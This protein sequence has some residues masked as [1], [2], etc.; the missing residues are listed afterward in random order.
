MAFQLFHMNELYSNADGSIQ[1]IELVG[2]ADGQL[3]LGGHTLT[4]TQD[5]TTH[6]YTFDADLPSAATLNRSVLVATQGFADLGVVTPDYIVPSGFLFTG[7]GT[8]TFAEGTGGISSIL[9][10]AALPTGGLLSANQTG[11]TAMNSPTNFAGATGTAGTPGPDDITGTAG[12]DHIFGLAANDNISGEGGDDTLD[13]GDGADLLVGDSLSNAGISFGSGTFDRLPDYN[14]GTLI[15]ALVVPGNRYS[16]AADDNISAATVLPHASVGSPAD[17]GGITHFYRISLAAGQTAF[18]DVDGDFDGA[19]R[20]FNPSGV[21]VARG[22]QSEVTQGAGG[23]NFP[24][25]PYI[26]YTASESGDYFLELG[27]WSD[28][29][30]LD[31]SEIID[32]IVAGHAYTLNISLAGFQSGTG[33]D[34]LSGGVGS[35]TLIGGAGDDTLTMMCCSAGTETTASYSTAA[36][37]FLISK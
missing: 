28:G 21:L 14:N 17:N 4:V 35:D 11:A 18:L 15:T 16:L 9:A 10:Y 34:V 7:G 36:P 22:D 3:F 27:V 5:T 24:L 20:L 19:M 1:F 2:D 8:I 26:A 37:T 23:S 32:A 12:V 25:D 33:N 6:A 29:T 31:E 13:G 30:I